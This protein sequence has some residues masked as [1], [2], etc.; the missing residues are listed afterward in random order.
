[1]EG[2][3]VRWSVSNLNVIS[4]HLNQTRWKRLA[5]KILVFLAFVVA[6]LFAVIGSQALVYEAFSSA[7]FYASAQATTFFIANTV[8]FELFF[9]H[10]SKTRNQWIN[11][12]AQ[13]FL[14]ARSSQNN[15]PVSRWRKKL[16]H[17]MV[18]AP[19]IF[20]LG[21]FLFFPELLG[22]VSHLPGQPSLDHYRLEIPLTWIIVYD[23]Q[24]YVDSRL[25]RSD[26]WIVA[27]KG[28]ARA[29]LSTYWHKEEPV[30]EIT[31]SF[32]PH[33]SPDEWFPE[34]AKVLSRQELLLGNETVICWD[35]IP[36]ADTRPKPIDPAFAEIICPAGENGFGA[37]FSGW[38]I[39][40][41][42][43]YK[44]LQQATRKS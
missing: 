39:D 27:T 13:K 33:D 28:I 20:V 17:R 10:R 8:M 44:A 18:W 26:T 14:A 21:V 41:P 34:H 6:Y 2:T 11:D 42:L 3:E 9:Y 38:R 24:T 4:N 7:P 43:F 31:L 37:H 40:Y 12:E 30:S 29:G 1:L 19:T 25:V 36:Y 35:I 23:N 15:A 16:R 22:V 5:E 32:A